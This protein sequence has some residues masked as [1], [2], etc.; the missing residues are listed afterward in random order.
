MNFGVA[1]RGEVHHGGSI[2]F[3]WFV[4]WYHNRTTV[5]QES[6]RKAKK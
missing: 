5:L 6:N 3:I 2:S 4:Y 1:Q